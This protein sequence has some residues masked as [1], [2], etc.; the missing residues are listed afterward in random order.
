ML[1]LKIDGPKRSM[2]NK[3]GIQLDQNL[4]QIISVTKCEGDEP[5]FFCRKR[6]Q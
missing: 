4:R 3:K 1:C 5:F 2:K 6:G